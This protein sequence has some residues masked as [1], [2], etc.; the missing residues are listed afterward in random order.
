M[1]YNP[2]VFISY[3]HDN[4]EHKEWV[5]KLASDLTRHGVKVIFDQ[6]DLRL[7]EDLRFFMEDGLSDARLVL[8]ICSEDY[9]KKV[10]GGEKGSGYEGMI[11]TQSL[12][13]NAKSEYIIPIIRNNSTEKKTPTAFGS[14][15]YIDFS[16]D[17]L[18][19]N[20][21]TELL[22]RIWGEDIK[23]KPLLGQN[24]FS[25]NLAN[26]IETKTKIESVLYH[27][28]TMNGDITF[29]YDNNNGKYIIGDGEYAFETQWSRSGNNSIYAYGNIGFKDNETEFPEF[30]KIYEYDFSSRARTIKT[31][32]IVIFKNSNGHFAAVKVGEVKSSNHG[33]PY[34]IMTFQYHIY[35]VD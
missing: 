3:S 30:N 2:C 28:S 22:E 24:P 25:N 31:G 23:K 15:A 20:K 8:C 19:I 1:E 12:L 9:V 13:K 4:D 34:D 17:D 33:N 6:W 18:Y 14:K 32:Q 35:E 10:D 16:D 11:I 27:S 5:L 21:Y 7:G 29:R 26:E